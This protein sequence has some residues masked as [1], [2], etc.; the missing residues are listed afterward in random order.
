MYNKTISRTIPVTEFTGMMVHIETRRI[1]DTEF[2]VVGEGFS[3]D[4]LI[5]TA[6]NTEYV[7]V[8]A[9]DISVKYFKCTMPVERFYG[10]CDEASRVECEVS[11]NLPE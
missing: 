2:H 11:E 3:L 7:C 9:R 8:A 5:K 1:F 10:M 4:E 6:T